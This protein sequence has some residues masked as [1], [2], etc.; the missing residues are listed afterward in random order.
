MGHIWVEV[1]TGNLEGTARRSVKA[2]V[3]TGATLTEPL[4]EHVKVEAGSVELWEIVND[5]ASMP[6]PMHLHGFPMWVVER[7]NS[8]RQVAELA[9]DYRGRL[10]TDLGLKDTVLIWPGETVK[11]VVKFDVAERGQLF[12]FHCHNLEHE[13][14]GL[15]IN[16]SI[17]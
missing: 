12:P 1:I 16:I 11:A 14:G 15:M 7:R 5:A 3:D 10:P 17:L 8:P 6:H 2:L 9:V 4:K 13:D